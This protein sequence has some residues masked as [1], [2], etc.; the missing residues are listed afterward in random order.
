MN[1]N[2]QWIFYE[3]FFIFGQIEVFE[4]ITIN[5][6]KDINFLDQ[7]QGNWAGRNFI[8]ASRVNS[9]LITHARM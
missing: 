2:E 1:V 7:I 6:F 3:N 4:W 8:N 5:F 9:Q